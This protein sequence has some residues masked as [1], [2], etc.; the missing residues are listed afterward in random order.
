MSRSDCIPTAGERTASARSPRW[1]A[2]ASLIGVMFADHG[3]ADEALIALMAQSGF[4]GVMIDTANK[5]DG[6]LLDHMNIASIGR[7]VACAHGPAA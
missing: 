5:T 6:R 2:G 4:A 7:F 3:G 1:H